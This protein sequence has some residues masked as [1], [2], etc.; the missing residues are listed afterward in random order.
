[1]LEGG[2]V[3]IWKE[4]GQQ[5]ESQIEITGLETCLLLMCVA[6]V[7]FMLRALIT[8]ICDNSNNFL[9]IIPSLAISFTIE[10]KI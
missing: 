8:V 1:V 5:Y 2:A 7:A 6:A 3:C 9:C 10:F 4:K